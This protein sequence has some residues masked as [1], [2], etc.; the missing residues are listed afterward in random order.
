MFTHIQNILNKFYAEYQD[1][2][3]ANDDP[4]S[5]TNYLHDAGLFFEEV[6]VAQ[7][8]KELS[9]FYRTRKYI[10]VFTR[11]PSLDII[12]SQTS[13]VHTLAPIYLR[14]VLMSPHL[15]LVLLIGLFPSDSPTQ[16][17]YARSIT[18]QGK[19]NCV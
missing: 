6:T 14:S 12:L 7:L 19:R 10:T 13:L 18:K 8:V 17:S 4:V 11:A 2:D 9:A 16:I 1:D 3:K 15:L 5:L